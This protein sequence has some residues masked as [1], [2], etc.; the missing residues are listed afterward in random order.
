MFIRLDNQRDA[1][2][3][4]VTRRSVPALH[5]VQHVT[6]ILSPTLCRAACTLDH[7]SEAQ[8]LG[9]T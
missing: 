8:D 2:A 7:L 4:D 3:D 6:V 5:G 1:E 9:A